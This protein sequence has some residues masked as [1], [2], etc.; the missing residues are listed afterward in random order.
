M[1]VAPSTQ[2]EFF[3][4]LGLSKDYTDTLYFATSAERDS[5]FSALFKIARAANCSYTREKRGF[6]RVEIPISTLYNASY[7]RFKND[8]FENKWFYA[9]VDSVNYINNAVTEVEYTIDVMLTWMG[10]FTLG[11]CFVERQHTISDKIGANIADEHL[12]TGDYICQGFY[13]TGLFTDYKVAFL[14][15]TDTDGVVGGGVFQGVYSGVF[16][17]SYELSQAA[18]T[19]AGM[20]EEERES[21]V[22]LKMYPTAFIGSYGGDD[23]PKIIA[24]DDVQKPYS[25]IAGYTPKN[26][27]LFCYPY[28]LLVVYNCEGETATYKY[29]YFNSLPPEDSS[30]SITCYFSIDGIVN[31]ECEISCIPRNYKGQQSNLT[32]R[33]TMRQFPNCAI[34]VDAYKA[35]I[36]QTESNL[37][38][39][40]AN[41]VTG[42]AAGALTG[43]PAMMAA[44]AAAGASGLVKDVATLAFD[45]LG[46]APTP[47]MPDQI[48]G[49]QSVNLLVGERIKDFYFYQ[50][51]VTRNYAEMIDDYFTAFGYAIR[52]IIQPS[53]AARQRFTYLKTAGCNVHGSIPAE[54]ARKIESI[55]DSGTR[56]WRNHAD[57]GNYSGSN[58]PLGDI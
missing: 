38:L 11:E 47:I 3:G 56:F 31:A 55:I 20:S 22:G 10:D 41:T 43:N 44:S 54:D 18:S 5:Y 23:Q 39:N 52:E 15:P 35:Y 30:T 26:N 32:E 37:P 48:K 4:D 16:V 42:I 24:Y 9:F 19:L 33:L 40:I 17:D 29:E 21:L 46:G 13:S 8:L 7:M 25:T 34:G 57:I 50:M 28:N 12:A 14:S 2:I 49:A 1:Y 53:M 36:A 27:K 45:A 6:V 58:L 51:C